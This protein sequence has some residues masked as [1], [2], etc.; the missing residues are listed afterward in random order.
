[1][2]KVALAAFFDESEKIAMD[3]AVAME[4]FG[5]PGALLEGYHTSGM[6]GMASTGLGAVGGMGAGMLAAHYVK[7]L[8]GGE[9]GKQHPILRTIADSAPVGIGG[10]IGGALGGHAA[11]HFK[12]KVAMTKE[13]I[14]VGALLEKAIKNAPI[15]VT[16]KARLDELPNRIRGVEEALAAGIPIGLSNV[17]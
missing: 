11:D 14:A 17:R 7:K 8:T 12:P 3:T 6:K 16:E 10:V 5:V 15:A 9:W 4:G 1:M 13:A 2:N